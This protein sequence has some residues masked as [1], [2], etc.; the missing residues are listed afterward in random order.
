MVQV[1]RVS[2]VFGGAIFAALSL[3]ACAQGNVTIETGG[4]GGTGAT[5]G[6]GAGGDTT[7]TGGGGSGGTTT[8][9]DGP[10]TKAEDCVA[11]SD[12]CNTGACI[13][14]ECG[15]LPANDG[16]ACDDGKTCTQN[17]YCDSGV[18]KSGTLKPCT[19]SD[20]C[21]VGTCDVT[22]DSCVEVPGN[23]GAPCN[24][25]DACILS[26]SCINGICQPN[27]QVDCSYLNTECSDGYCDPVGGCKSTPKNDG[28]AC[29]DFLFC[30]VQDQCVSGQCKGFPNT[31]AVAQGDPC[32]TGVC[33]E[34]Q[35]TCVQV[36]GN[37]G[38]ACDDTNLCTMGEKCLAGTCVGGTPA[39]EGAACDDANGCTGG[40]SCVAGT[41]ANP[42]SEIMAC[43]DGDMC[44]PAGCANDKDCLWW[45]SGV[46]QNVPESQLT[47]WTECFKDKYDNY[48]TPM[49]TILSQCDKG[50]L[51]LACRPVGA[52]SL[53]TLAMGLR[54]DVLYECGQDSACVHAA[55]GV[56]W[57]YSDSYSWGYA[58]GGE[59]VARTSCDTQSTQNPD[60]LC[61]HSG[62]GLINGGWRC[63]SATGL[64]SD[65]SWERI[66]YEA[67]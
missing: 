42:Q 66:V 45:V 59:A 32:K 38:A 14:G 23:N 30:T 2:L 11:F 43:V 8:T 7:T 27:Q 12:A 63:G 25:G 35:K 58:P 4:S 21:M 19:A 10:C 22:T 31:C 61:W 47:G 57:Y 1:S 33:N 29:N 64:N 49:S 39:N 52:A 44:C 6:G 28:A 18:C 5:G 62:G 54:A 65:P 53:S 55:N 51:L 60:R 50:K 46:Q 24:F 34:A 41:C 9:T 17:D 40:T 20:P 36:A 16:S 26:A 15:V 48:N 56:G 3:T 13:N 37:D 67:D